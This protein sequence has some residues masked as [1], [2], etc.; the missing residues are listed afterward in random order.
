MSLQNRTEVVARAVATAQWRALL[1]VGTEQDAR[2]AAMVE[3]CWPEY[4]PLARQ[5]VSVIE[6]APPESLPLL[7]GQREYLRE[8]AKV[9]KSKL[10]DNYGFIVLA[11]PLGEPNGTDR[12]TYLSSIERV[13]AIATLKEWLLKCGA[14]EDWMKHIT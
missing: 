11:V 12:V 4:A 6:A 1:G 13:D 5:L 3:Q 9:L 10:P 2:A 14:A 7:A 8:M